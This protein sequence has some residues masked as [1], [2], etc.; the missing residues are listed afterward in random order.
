MS[1]ISATVR[2]RMEVEV[3]IGS[4]GAGESFDSLRE[5]AIREAKQKMNNVL[6]KSSG[7][8]MVGEAKSMHVILEGEIKP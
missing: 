1:K 7:C 2:V 5:T 6:A 4:W 3:T 8:R